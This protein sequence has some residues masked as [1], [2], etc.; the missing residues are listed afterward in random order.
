MTVTAAQVKELRDKSGAG[1]MDAKKA[2]VENNGDMEAAMDW[3]RTK[4]IAKAAKKASRVA[5]EG[6]VLATSN[7]T[8]GAMVEVNSETDFAAKNEKFQEFADTML[9]LVLESGESNVDT[10][11][12]MTYPN[13]DITVKDKQTELVATIGENISLR[14]AAYASNES[15]TVGAY[16]HMGGKIGV[17]TTISGATAQDEVAKQIAMHV[18]ASAP[19]FLTRDDINP[20]VLAREKA[21]YE[22]Q[23]AA[24]GKPEN[25][26]QK[27]VDG[28]M[29]KFAEEI[30]LVDQAFVMDTDRKVGQV[31]SEAASGASL[32]AFTRF[33]LGEGIEKK[34]ED[35]AAEV[36]AAVNG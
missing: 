19:Q 4:G 20:D 31:V 23:A 14:R 32:S 11:L 16:V 27:I 29:N 25:V 24:S 5:A 30:C 13:S 28:R 3:L 35:F 7:G 36:A 1:M 2:L 8:A 15:G 10:L 17:L 33:A 21:I 6:K 26:V 12:G 22:E 9:N 18:A 34:E